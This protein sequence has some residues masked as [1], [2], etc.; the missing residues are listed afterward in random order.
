MLS[1]LR[2][3][4]L[5]ACLPRFSLNC[6]R[7]FT[8]TSN[9]RGRPPKNPK[10]V[11]KEASE[12]P[13][14]AQ[15]HCDASEWDHSLAT[16]L[17]HYS[18]LPPLPPTDDWLTHF[19]YTSPQ[20]RDRISIRTPATAIGLAHSFMNSKKTSTNN[21]KV[22][23]EAFPGPGALS[24]AFL[25]LPSSQLRRL[26]ILEDHEPYLEYLRPLARADP[27]VRLV[28]RSGFSWDTYSYLAE[29]GDLDVDIAPWENIHPELHFVTHIT[30]TVHGEQLVAQ[31][32]RCIP[33]KSW[34]FKY[35]RIPMSFILAN[36]VLRRIS[37]PL[38]TTARCKLS[39][40]AEA[41]SS[42][43]RSLPPERLSPFSDHFHPA[44]TDDG[45]V[46]LQSVRPETRR[47]GSPFLAINVLPHDEQVIDKGMLNKWDYVLRRLFVLKSTPLRKAITS[48]AP[49]ADVLLRPLT[50]KSLP[51]EQRVDIRLMVKELTVSDWALIVRAFDDW[52]FAPNELDIDSF[53]AYERDS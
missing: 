48:L 25:T 19:P 1:P 39:V 50:D 16:S 52:P 49:G 31:L 2:A 21:P 29:N 30:Q 47:R 8:S 14:A 18:S 24:R 17:N 4:H 37:A 11:S 9:K 3:N 15:L 35:G 20:V 45:R 34:L 36:W 22:I 46:G 13:A 33:E 40:I 26:I 6:T 38:K 53:I 23:I 42:F 51:P 12:P 28:S 10:V 32:F 7:N 44:A 5:V 27:R 41:T 43:S